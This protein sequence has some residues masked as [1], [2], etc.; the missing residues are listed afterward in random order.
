MNLLEV[1]LSGAV[2]IIAVIMIRAAA[3]HKL[4]KKS[5]LVLWKT[6]LL[7]LLIPLPLPSAFSIYTLIHRSK[8]TPSVLE[9]ENVNIPSA[10]A[11]EHFIIA[12]DL[13]TLPATSPSVSVWFVVWC[14]GMILLA[15]FFTVSYL[16]CRMEFRT[17]F[18]VSNAFAKQWT[19]KRPFMRQIS[20]KQSD[21]ISTP[22]TYGI[23]RP[24]IL[25]P[26]HTDWENTE[27]LQYIL[28]HEYVH[29]RRFDTLTKL[30]ATFALCI[31]WFNPLVWVMYL[32]FNRDIELACDESVIRQFG[33]S[34]KSAYSMMPI[35]MEAKKSGLSLLCNYF[36]KNAAEERITAIMK[37]KR[38]TPGTFLSACLIVL[39]TVSLF[40]TTARASADGSPYGRPD[41]RLVVS[42]L[43]ASTDTTNTDTVSAGIYKPDLDNPESTARNF[44]ILLRKLLLSA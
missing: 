32:L 1:S 9:T 14:T 43:L 22:L 23:F 25:M 19:A 38:T 11:Q 6:V 35:G 41:D 12:Q 44:A 21:R 31:H 8:S 13:E 29:I 28:S 16:R 4:P 37:I 5:F 40:A 18:P 34:A 30:I 26:K 2:F 17:A 42:D 20:I 3:I 24:V 36:S 33:E 27:Q 7:R 10:I 15:V 39:V